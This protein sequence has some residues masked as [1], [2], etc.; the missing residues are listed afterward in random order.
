ML[1]TEIDA[2]NWNAIPTPRLR[3]RTAEARDA[4]RTER[5]DPAA[6]LRALAAA[7]DLAEVAS[8]V[9][10]LTSNSLLRGRTGEVLPAAVVAA[11]F[12]LD[13]AEHGHPHARESA[14][15]LLDGTMRSAPL[16]D[17][18]RFR[19]PAGHDAP[20][21]CAIAEVVRARRDSLAEHG[22]S[23]KYLLK[24]SDAHWRFEIREAAGASDDVVALGTLQGA[25]PAAPCA[26]EL[27]HGGALTPVGTVTVECP[28][29]DTSAEACLRL[30]GVAD[31]GDLAG[32]VLYPAACGVRER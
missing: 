17:F 18:S 20:L 10:A 21:C 16:A 4:A 1:L 9:S 26:G 14:V 25:L 7:R 8:A 11:P 6:G 22:R 13:I 3:P 23:G 30:T 28:P 12:L 24:A 32:A 31:G 29:V 27:H 15:V 5:P 2:V 19:T